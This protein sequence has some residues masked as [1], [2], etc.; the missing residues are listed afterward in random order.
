[1]MNFM[2]RVVVEDTRGNKL[3]NIAFDTVRKTYYV[4][5]SYP[6]KN[7]NEK[8]IKKVKTFKTLKE[9]RE[10]LIVFEAEKIKEEI[11][12][13]CNITLGQ[14]IEQ[15]L[16]ND[17]AP[18]KAKTTYVGYCTIARN[19]IIPAIGDIK[20]QDLNRLDIKN[21][22]AIKL[23]G[24]NLKK[25]LSG[26][27]IRNHHT[28]LYSVLKEAERCEII[29][30]NP[31]VNITLPEYV[32]PNIP[33]YLPEQVH[34]LLKAVENEW[35]LY[36][37]V[38]LVCY[39]GLRRE[40]A[41][42]LKWEDFDF[43]KK[44]ISVNKARVVANR[45]V[46]EKEPKSKSSIRTL[47][48][49]PELETVLKNVRK[50][51]IENK[52]LLGHIYTDSGYVVVGHN[53]EPLNPGSVSAMFGKFIK[54]NKE[55]EHIHLHGLRHTFASVLINNGIPIYYVSKIMGHQSTHITE[56]TYAH[57]F[58]EMHE[59]I[60][61]TINYMDVVAKNDEEAVNKDALTNLKK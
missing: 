52:E 40:E 2:S 57:L 11:I 22:Y 14:W 17:V 12:S 21:Y 35:V 24:E 32:K 30:K 6:K 1:M 31:A 18:Y 16:I 43:D 29:K 37:L 39:L 23:N 60:L 48:I 56:N 54:K 3:K 61:S 55:L 4:T 19:H 15:Y 42:A 44:I 27:T 45:Q 47:F 8:R 51:Q 53:G 9:A 25:P 58:K 49:N 5:L 20:I 46:I 10:C 38:Y 7:K 13:P 59:D 36:P 41:L 33:Y 34:L 50:K 26:N 28:F